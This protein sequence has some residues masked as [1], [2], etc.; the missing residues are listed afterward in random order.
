MHSNARESNSHSIDVRGFT[1]LIPA[2]AM[3]SHIL[4]VKKATFAPGVFLRFKLIS[5]VSSQTLLIELIRWRCI[6]RKMWV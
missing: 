4:V 5:E 6:V 2:I 1:G 3:P